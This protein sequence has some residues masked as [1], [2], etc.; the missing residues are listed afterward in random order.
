[1]KRIRSAAEGNV[2]P[3]ILMSLA[4][5][6]SIWQWIAFLPCRAN[7]SDGSWNDLTLTRLCFLRFNIKGI[8]CSLTKLN[9]RG[10]SLHCALR[11]SILIKWK[12]AAPQLFIHLVKDVMHFLKPENTHSKGPLKPL[13]GTGGL[14]WI[15]VNLYNR[16]LIKSWV[17]PIQ[18]LV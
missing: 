8:L 13:K 6:Q 11:C 7:W 1:M 17:F 15:C 3:I 18:V 10:H 12:Q 2:Q 4:T 16:P 9:P 5:I 14:F